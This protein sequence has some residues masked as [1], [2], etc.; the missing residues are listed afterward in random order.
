MVDKER[1]QWPRD[2]YLV[3]DEM[4]TLFQRWSR[5]MTDGN[6]ILALEELM[7]RA[8]RARDHRLVAVR[9]TGAD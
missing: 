3:I 8:Q 7:E 4:E 1:R 5:S 6:Y 2:R 9:A